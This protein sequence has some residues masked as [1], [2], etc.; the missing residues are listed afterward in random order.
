MFDGV[1]ADYYFSEKQAIFWG[2][3]I[4]LF[5]AGITAKKRPDFAPIKDIIQGD[6]LSAQMHSK[7][8]SQSDIHG[9]V[10]KKIVRVEHLET[11]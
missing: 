8:R 1:N 2:S 5:S 9:I 6:F 7:Q 4:R 10:N 3:Q 11:P